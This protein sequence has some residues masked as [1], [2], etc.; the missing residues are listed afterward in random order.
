MKNKISKEFFE[1][2]ATS[3]FITAYHY[4]VILLLLT[5]TAYTQA[6][7]ADRLGL[8]RQN[9][10]RC[11]KE[12]EERGYILVDRI[13]GRNKFIKANLSVKDIRLANS[14]ADE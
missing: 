7:I 5:G 2:L 6:Q 1:L 12:L 13:E 14:V 4:R 8:K 10:H 11:V 3:N 9:V